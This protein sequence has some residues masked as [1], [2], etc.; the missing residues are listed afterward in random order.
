[1]ISPQPV[2]LT[3]V[4]LSPSTVSTRVADKDGMRQMVGGSLLEQCYIEAVL[5]ELR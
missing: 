3:A 2:K 4:V 1:M 5:K